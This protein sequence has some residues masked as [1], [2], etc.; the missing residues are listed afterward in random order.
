MRCAGGDMD[1]YKG[2]GAKGPAGLGQGG[3]T[4]KEAGAWL[5]RG[6]LC[7]RVAGGGFSRRGNQLVLVLSC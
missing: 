1:G 7:R 6:C 2:C 5:T 4:G 3:L